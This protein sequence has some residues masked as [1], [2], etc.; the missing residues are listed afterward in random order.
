MVTLLDAPLQSANT[1]PS[2]VQQRMQH[3]QFQCATL[4]EERHELDGWIDQYL[5]DI[6]LEDFDT[7]Q[8]DMSRF[9]D[10]IEGNRELS[11]RQ[12]DAIVQQQAYRAVEFLMLKRRLSHLRFE[13]QF[14]NQRPPFPHQNSR[15]IIRLNPTYVWATFETDHFIDEGTP[16]PATV[17]FFMVNGALKTALLDEP[18]IELL[19]RLE[20]S[21]VTVRRV[22]SD[23]PKDQRQAIAATITTLATLG[24]IVLSA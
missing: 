18:A 13:Q 23:A 9:L 8:S 19:H 5:T 2:A 12:R 14:Q 4:A 24:V 1:V 10:W 20:R 7:D 6:P 3:L 15:S 22:L 16:V 17:V 11:P 21:D